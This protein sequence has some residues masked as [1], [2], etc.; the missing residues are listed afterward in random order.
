[1]SIDDIILLE[2]LPDLSPFVL[3][4][5]CKCRINKFISLEGYTNLLDLDAVLILIPR[6]ESKDSDL[7]VFSQASS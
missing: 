2:L 3:E 4:Q 7:V 5:R 6:V 1:M